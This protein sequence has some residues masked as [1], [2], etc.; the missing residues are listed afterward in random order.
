MEKRQINIIVI[1]GLML[2]IVFLLFRFGGRG[3]YSWSENYLA[4]NKGPYGTDI[5]RQLLEDYHSGENFEVME[6]SIAILQEA[7][8]PSNYVFIGASQYLD[9]LSI[10]HL[11]NFVAAGNRAFIISRSLAEEL[12]EYTYIYD[13]YDSYYWD[14]YLEHRDTAVDLSMRHAD[15]MENSGSH[16]AFQYRNKIEKY[17]WQYIDDV[18]ICKESLIELGTFDEM[19]TNFARME[20]GEGYLYLHTNPILFSN[21]ALLDQEKLPYIE[22]VFSHMVEGP[23]YWDEASKIPGFLR[24]PRF[25]KQLSDKGPFEYILQQPPLRWAWYLLLTMAGLYL[26]FR[27]KRRQRIIPVLPKNYNTSLEFLQTIGHLYFLQNDHRKIA[28]HKSRLF[29]SFIRDR[30]NIPTQDLG[31]SFVQQLSLK[32]EIPQEDIKTVLLLDR[33]IKTSAF[34]SAKVLV[35]FHHKIEAFYKNCK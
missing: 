16:L 13:C 30:Y 22:A 24:N 23:I 34:L 25:P 26:L 14:G 20:Y 18:Y 11:T 32:S 19:F 1:V 4:E 3:G 29:L 17:D 7:D 6:D 10:E 8:E 21:Y 9:S 35:N 15:L 28:L 12:A 27:T 31:E 2:L 33:N 5:I